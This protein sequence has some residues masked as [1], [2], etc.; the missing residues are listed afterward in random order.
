MPLLITDD[1][2]NLVYK[3]RAFSKNGAAFFAAEEE[4]VAA[5]AGHVALCKDVLVEGRLYHFYMEA[6]GLHMPCGVSL[7]DTVD[8]LFSVDRFAGEPRWQFPL[9]CLPQILADTYGNT[10]RQEGIWLEVRK[11]K[12]A[13]T[14]TVPLQALLLLLALMARLCSFRGKHVC[15]SAVP[16][17]GGARI[18]ADAKIDSD[19]TVPLVLTSLFYEIAAAVGFAAEH[20]EKNG[21]VTWELTL[22]PPDIGLLGFKAPL[23][24][25][26]L[27]ICRIFAE[28]LL[29]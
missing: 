12:L 23:W 26:Y 20:Y 24:E 15:L 11:L 28:V 17:V 2:G 13:T 3:S 6:D 22:C 4:T 1:S 5:A 19:G 21:T 29:K 7:T 16:T 27:A 8:R 14:V 18:F 10:L 9:L 25:R